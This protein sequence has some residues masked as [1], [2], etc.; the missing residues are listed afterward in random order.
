MT[1]TVPK[2]ARSIADTWRALEAVRGAERTF[3]PATA[4][5]L[6][7]PA[8][9][10]LTHA[11]AGG[12][13]LASAAR[14]RMHGEIRV[15]AWRRFHADQ[16]LAPGLGYIWAATS[17]LFGVPV[18]GFDRFTDGQGQMRWRMAGRLPVM[19]AQDDDVTRSAAG[20]L[21]G[22]SVLVPT[23]FSQASWTSTTADT[24]EM[25]WTLP[26][27]FRGRATLVVADD[28]S[29][30]EVRMQRW[31]NPFGDGYADHTFVVELGRERT[32]GGCTVPTSLR[33]RW[34]D[35]SAINEFFHAETDDLHYF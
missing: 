7:T 15:G 21:I 29:L 19:S 16:I 12:T 4:A 27:G 35:G 33:A 32:F 14:L 24:A 20:R 10:W 25:T 6:P 13:P 9:R 11:V 22:E 31:G 3:D 28:G 18:S 5:E 34:E 8:R 30:D 23:T 1:A 26:N 2:A 17:S